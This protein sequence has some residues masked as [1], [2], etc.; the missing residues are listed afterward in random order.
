MNLQ[1]HTR[2]T[3]DVVL[4]KAW[5]YHPILLSTCGR[6][7]LMHITDNKG[8]SLC[9]EECCFA[10]EW[11]TYETRQVEEKKPTCDEP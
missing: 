10:M 6:K 2:H 11:T 5:G 4:V 7:R 3:V 9:L 1:I 8:I